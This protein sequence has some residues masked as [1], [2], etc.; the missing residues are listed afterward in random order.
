MKRIYL[1]TVDGCFRPE[2]DIILSPACL[3]AYEGD[4][5]SIKW[6]ASP[7]ME[8]DELDKA[9]KLCQQYAEIILGRMLSDL[10]KECGVNYSLRFWR[11]VLMPW[12]STLIQVVYERY[13]RLLCL[14]KKHRDETVSIVIVDTTEYRKFIDTLDFMVTVSSDD[15]FNYWLNSWLLIQMG[16]PQKWH[17]SKVLL[18][19][20]KPILPTSTSRQRRGGIKEALKKVYSKC[21]QYLPFMSV[22][23]IKPLQAFFLMAAAFLGGLI[24]KRAVANTHENAKEFSCFSDCNMNLFDGVEFKIIL[25]KMRPEAL[26]LL[27]IKN[28]FFWIKTRIYG[29]VFYYQEA[30]K[31][32]LAVLAEKNCN[33]LEVQHGASYGTARSFPLSQSV[34]YQLN[35]FITWGWTEHCGMHC[36]FIPLPSPSMS[37]L[38]NSLSSEPNNNENIIFIGTV[39]R[40]YSF[41]LDSYLQPDYL[42][43]Y[44]GNK[45]KFLD[46]LLDSLVGRVCYRPYPQ[47]EANLKDMDFVRKKYPN[48]RGVDGD[49]MKFCQRASLV[50]L[51]HPGTAMHQVLA[52]NIPIVC[53]WSP[54]HFALDESA[55]P[56]FE[57]L[58]SASILFDDPEKAAEHINSIEGNILQ[59][60][61]HEKTQRARKIWVHQ[62]ARVDKYWFWKWL[63]FVFISQRHL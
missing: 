16:I 51:D 8:N 61:Q 30:T 42:F 15:A 26:K 54:E 46:A 39:M 37:R 10:N 55:K 33:L 62:F 34:S 3:A 22:Y 11:I 32:K 56:Y 17:V 14:L 49:L 50:V 9:A 6:T 13:V 31:L 48:I 20:S 40:V 2:H 29:P 24:S 43:E 59:W 58:K 12:L 27:K 28:H 63:K 57:R 41:R 52:M 4:I 47:P 5:S 44:R 18:S 21:F 60:W 45:L 35:G 38:S 36:K 53:F 19:C 1:T 7:M 25:E 23:G